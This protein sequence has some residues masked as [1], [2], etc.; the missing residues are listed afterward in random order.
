[1]N[2]EYPNCIRYSDGMPKGSSGLDNLTIS[3]NK[4]VIGQTRGN[5]SVGNEVLVCY[6][7][8]K[9]KL[10]HAFGA[11]ITKRL[12]QSP[13]YWGYAP[14]YCWEIEPTSEITTLT[15]RTI[16]DKILCHKPNW[17]ITNSSF[18]GGGK[19]VNS[20]GI[21]RIKILSYIKK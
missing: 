16:E 9:N 3:F 13:S 2:T 15:E 4:R 19:N 8:K 17:Q 10:L 7:D 18:M 5:L 21:P 11:K 12:S 1:M 6:R 14:K 20:I